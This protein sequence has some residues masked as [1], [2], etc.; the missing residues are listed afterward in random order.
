MGKKEDKKERNLE[1]LSKD[2]QNKYPY[3]RGDQHENYSSR[4]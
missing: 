2:S 4:H 3:T 1:R